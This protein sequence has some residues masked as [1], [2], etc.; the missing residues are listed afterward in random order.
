LFF[1]FQKYTALKNKERQLA[2]T[3]AHLPKDSFLPQS[4]RLAFDLRAPP[5]VMETDEFKGLADTMADHTTA[6][7]EQAKQAI[8][9]VANL[10]KK[11]IHLDIITHFLC[12]SLEL[13]KLFLLKHNLEDDLSLAAALVHYGIEKQGNTFLV[14]FLA[15]DNNALVGC[16]QMIQKLVSLLPT[17]PAPLSAIFADQKTNLDPIVGAFMTLLMKIFVEAWTCQVKAHKAAAS[18]RTMAHKVKTYLDGAATQAAAMIINA[19]ALVDPKVLCNLIKTQVQ[20][21]NKKLQ[22]KLDKL[23]QMITRTPGLQGTTPKKP[24]T[25]CNHSPTPKKQ[26]VGPAPSSIAPCHQRKPTPSEHQPQNAKLGTTH[27]MVNANRKMPMPTLMPKMLQLTPMCMLCN[28]TKETLLPN[29]RRRSKPGNPT[30]TSSTSHNA[31]LH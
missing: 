11:A 14:H 29:Q 30:T 20:A 21:D 13:T 10:E 19:E 31:M 25:S 28:L 3:H 4:A 9:T 5:N 12:S 7:K 18:E 27:T 23:E 6:W 8:L 2:L 22:Q 15:T 17:A 24:P 16:Q 26:P 1:F